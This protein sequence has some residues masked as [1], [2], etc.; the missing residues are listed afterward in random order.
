MT[1]ELPLPA[2]FLERVAHLLGREVASW[3][4]PIGGY[5]PATRAIVGFADGTSVF[6]KSGA[7]LEPLPVATWLREEHRWYEELDGAP[8]MPRFVAWEDGAE[9]MLVIE[10]LSGAYWPPPWSPEHI[11]AVRDVV[12]QLAA[13]EAP[14]WAPRLEERWSG[15]AGL[16]ARIREE[17]APFLAL[18]LASVQWL[19]ECVDA[20]QAAAARA[21]TGGD[22][23]VHGDIRSDNVCV[24]AEGAKLVDW[25]WASRGNPL[26]DLTVWLPSL[27]REG[28]PAPWQLLEDSRGTAAL[29]AGSLASR[30]SEPPGRTEPRVRLLQL[31]LLRSALAWTARELGLP[32]LDGPRSLPFL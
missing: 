28:G 9:P 1:A 17:P 19:D 30:L 13:M 25:N 22:Q 26:F 3:T 20:L 32:P 16:W 23:I 14:A 29:F 31:D 2:F 18:G 10:D 12:D 21:D 7:D 6:A 24:T 27:P 15:L 4:Q 11:G 8:F 5:T